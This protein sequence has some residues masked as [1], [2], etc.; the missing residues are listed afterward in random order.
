MQFAFCKFLR[1]FSR[2]YPDCKLE[3]S[4]IHTYLKNIDICH[5]CA[6]VSMCRAHRP[7]RS[8]FYEGGRGKKNGARGNRY[9]LTGLTAPPRLRLCIRSFRG[10]AQ[11]PHSSLPVLL[12]SLAF[13]YPFPT[14]LSFSPSPSLPL[15]PSLATRSAC[16]KIVKLVKSLE[17]LSQ[18]AFNSPSRSALLFFPSDIR[19]AN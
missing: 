11:P 6:R 13:S 2:Y 19:T 16:S 12:S 7:W 18:S 14:F 8:H 9:C 4:D 10:A 1:N 3:E 15:F 5:L 17:R